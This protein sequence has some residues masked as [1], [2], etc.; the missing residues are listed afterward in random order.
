MNAIGKYE[1]LFQ[2]SPE[3]FYLENA[4]MF[5]VDGLLAFRIFEGMKCVEEHYYPMVSIHRV[6]KVK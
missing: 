5:C 6:K 4:R 1:I 2:D 3:Y